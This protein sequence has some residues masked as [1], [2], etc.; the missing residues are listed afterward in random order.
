MGESFLSAQ[1]VATM[2]GVHFRTVYRYVRHDGLPAY[3]PGGRSG[4]FL[5]K[6]EDVERWLRE[7][8]QIA[9]ELGE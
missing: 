5:F 3:Q 6:R 4:K 7:R 1:Q 9:D 8:M 2:L